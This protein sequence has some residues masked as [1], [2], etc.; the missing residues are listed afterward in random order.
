M[1]NNKPNL[2]QPDLTFYF[3]IHQAQRDAITRYRDAVSVLTEDD[4]RIR[5]KALARWSKGMSSQLDEHHHVED[6]FFFPSL[7]AKVPAVE[8]ILDRLDTDHQ[9]L[10]RLLAGWPAMS[11]RLA[12]PRVP[13]QAARAELSTFADELHA[14]LHAHLE[15]EDQDILPLFWRH[16]TG[17][18][19]LHLEQTAVKKG[20][21]SGMAFVAPFTVDCFAEGPERDAFLASV[22]AVLRVFHRIVRPGY[23]RLTAAA[24]GHVGSASLL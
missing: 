20:K 9:T 15:V 6:R 4:R 22:P 7:R 13:F 19:Y 8:A 1:T 18:E 12:D 16:Y 24:F 3:S 23:D 10:D 2:T 11:A 14:L 17:E 21:K 5:G